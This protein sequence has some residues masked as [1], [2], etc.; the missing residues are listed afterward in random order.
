MRILIAGEGRTPLHSGE[1][2]ESAGSQVKNDKSDHRREDEHNEDE[3]APHKD[4]SA[5]IDFKSALVTCAA[6]KDCR[7]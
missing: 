3:E 7:L 4:L 6:S 1:P 5:P 2:H